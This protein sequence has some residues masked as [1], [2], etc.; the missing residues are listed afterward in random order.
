MSDWIDELIARWASD[1]VKLNPGAAPERL[2]R[3]ERRHGVR[4]SDA[5]K[6]LYLRVDGMPDLGCDRHHLSLWPLDQISREGFDQSDDAHFEF[7]DYLILS[8]CYAVPRDAAD[9]DPVSV[10]GQGYTQIA[11]S[12][13]EFWRRVLHNPTSVHL[14]ESGE[15][16]G[17]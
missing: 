10:S 7:A 3:F 8:H 2:R 6:A 1:G 17:R 5:F 9:G 12:F 16:L 13:E 14:I 11:A 15:A 4:L